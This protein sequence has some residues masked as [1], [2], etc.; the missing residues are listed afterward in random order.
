MNLR[1]NIDSEGLAWQTGVWDKMSDVY[2]EEVDQRFVPV[3]D[4][5]ISRAAI[6]SGDDVLDLGTGTGSVALRVAIAHMR[7]RANLTG[8]EARDVL[9]FL[10]GSN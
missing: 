1:N 4:G 8:Q 9:V 7:V 2:L 3:I 5:V 6:T 10:Q